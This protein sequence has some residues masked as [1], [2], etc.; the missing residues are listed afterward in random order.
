[1]MRT[2]RSQ[3]AMT[4]IEVMTAVAIFSMVG[5]LAFSSIH[6]SLKSQE[7]SRR[8]SERYHSGRMAMERMKK[9]L[10]MAFISLHQHEDKRTITVFEGGPQKLLF[11]STSH[12]PIQRDTY[13]SDQVE[14]EYRLDTVDGESVLVRR[15]KHHIDDRPGDGGVEE[16]I[17]TG[18]ERVTFRYY[19]EADETWR[20]DWS[21]RVEDAQ[22]MRAHLK[23]VR[24]QAENLKEA[25]ATATASSGAL[26]ST[27][28]DAQLDNAAD[29]AQGQLLEELFL[30]A[31]VSIRLVL[32]DDND[33]EYLLE[34]QAEITMT[35]PLWY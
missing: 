13:Q 24:E 19:D 34:T 30:P 33:R 17:V 11:M 7:R 16:I 32:V 22:E 5:V 15:V 6:F 4:L 27:L 18:V 8:L 28:A 26:A 1:M 3:R 29:D 12:Q 21:V 14:I 31:R 9:E 20:D 23:L 2:L 10:S 35:E 25:V